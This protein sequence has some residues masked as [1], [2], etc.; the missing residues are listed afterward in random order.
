M[1]KGNC[2]VKVLV[3]NGKRNVDIVS[4]VTREHT[5]QK[6]PEQTNESMETQGIQ[7]WTSVEAWQHC[8][9]GQECSV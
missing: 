5:T 6:R 4:T 3:V 1:K 2:S 9:P 8:Q 7:T